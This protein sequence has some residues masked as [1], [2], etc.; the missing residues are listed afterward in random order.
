VDFITVSGVA[1]AAGEAAE[2]DVELTTTNN[3][4]AKDRHCLLAFKNN[5]FQKTDIKMF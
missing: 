1:Q 2:R 4:T 5:S 3:S